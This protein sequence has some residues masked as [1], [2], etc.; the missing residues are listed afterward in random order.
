MTKINGCTL[1]LFGT[2]IITEEQEQSHMPN[3]IEIRKISKHYA[4]CK[5]LDEVSFTIK[6][7]GV[8]ALLGENGAG[9]TTLFI[10]LPIIIGNG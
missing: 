4:D 5:A 7:G 1:P 10:L 3:P 2:L 9:K 8:T 6:A